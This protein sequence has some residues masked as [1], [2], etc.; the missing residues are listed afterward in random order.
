MGKMRSGVLTINDYSLGG[1]NALHRERKTVRKTKGPGK[2]GEKRNLLLVHKK[3]EGKIGVEE[4][5]PRLGGK[6]GTGVK[7]NQRGNDKNSPPQNEA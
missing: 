1:K 3:I 2:V 5:K 6:T 4:M 7:K